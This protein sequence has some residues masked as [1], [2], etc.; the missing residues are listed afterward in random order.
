MHI[1]RENPFVNPSIHYRVEHQ[2]QFLLTRAQFFSWHMVFRSPTLVP[3]EKAKGDEEMRGLQLLLQAL[4]GACSKSPPLYFFSPNISIS[5][6]SPLFIYL[7][8]PRVPETQPIYRM[9]ALIPNVDA[10]QCVSRAPINV[11]Q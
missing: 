10:M 11:N 2:V 5:L 9:S 6:F 3:G 7:V 8:L 4:P 1:T